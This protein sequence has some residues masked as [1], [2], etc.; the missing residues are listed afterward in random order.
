MRY[1][2]VI[3]LMF[4]A[5]STK[6]DEFVESLKMAIEAY[7]NGDVFEAKEEV[8]FAA[9]LLAYDLGTDLAKY[10]P[11]ATKGW[12]RDNYNPVEMVDIYGFGVVVYATYYNQDDDYIDIEFSYGEAVLDPMSAAMFKTTFSMALMGPVVRVGD[13]RFV[14]I[15]GDLEGVIGN[16]FVVAYGSA[17]QEEKIAY[18][19]SI[20]FESLKE[21]QVFGNVCAKEGRLTIAASHSASFGWDA[22]QFLLS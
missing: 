2:I 4:F 7:E 21:F 22:R 17:S 6:A 20:D 15:E 16:V 11:D 19:E 9:Q 13:E 10:L 3:L 18:L 5:N 12:T 1:F 8:D 14:N